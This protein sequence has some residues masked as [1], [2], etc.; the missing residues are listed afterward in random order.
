MNPAASAVPARFGT[1]GHSLLFLSSAWL[2]RIGLALVTFEQIRPFFSMQV[3]DYCFFFSLLLLLFRPEFLS[4]RAQD[5]K[6]L[7]GGWLVLLG[8]LVSLVN[9]SSLGETLAPLARFIVLFCLFAP[10]A[11]IHSADMRK[12]SF[13]LL[14]GISG[15]CVITLIQAT[16]FPGIVDLLS[17]NPARPDVTVVG[18][19][20]GLTSHPNIIGL[21]A[22]LAILL[23]IGLMSVEGNK[24]LRGWLIVAV[25]VCGIAA[26]L[27]GSRAV[28]V[29]LIPG[30]AVLALSQK[31]R[32]RTILRM[33][34]ALMVV[35]GAVTYLI[36]AVVSQFGERLNT[37]GVDISSDYGR[38]WS[39]VY[40]IGEISQKPIIGWGIDHLNDAGL[41]EVPWT[42]EIVGVHNTFLK[43]WHAAGLLGAIG[44]VALFVM[45]I[46]LMRSVLKRRSENAVIHMLALGLGCCTLLFIVSNL[47]PFD[48]NRFLYIPV[49]LFGGFAVRVRLPVPPAATLL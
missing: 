18:R 35:W 3:S 30:L 29:S 42:G 49:F 40:A 28:F 32:K 41:T 15:N 8:S 45:P 22:G 2:F 48:Y 7:I 23:G 5:F 17:V 20:Q 27:S 33:L 37:S 14:A 4:L 44:F 47:G 11:V 10:L 26:L 9:S 12:N 36:P 21:V 16:I 34:L 24:S 13:Y 25:A 39:A 6:I 43:Y 1:R 46:R 38:L 31:Q 19:F